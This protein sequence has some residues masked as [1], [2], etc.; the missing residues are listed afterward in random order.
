MATASKAVSKRELLP[1]ASQGNWIVWTGV[2][3]QD[4]G[5]DPSRVLGDEEIVLGELQQPM[6]RYT[7]LRLRV[8]VPRHVRD[9]PVLRFREGCKEAA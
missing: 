8:L 2:K 6:D 1:Q 7:I 4:C 3:I 9:L 5:S